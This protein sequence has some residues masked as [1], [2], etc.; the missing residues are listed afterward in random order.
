MWEKRNIHRE[1]SW[2]RCVWFRFRMLVA[3][4]TLNLEYIN[5]SERILL[6]KRNAQMA[7]FRGTSAIMS[8][9]E[10]REL[11]EV[12][13]GA[14]PIRLKTQ[15]HWRTPALPFW[16]NLKF[17]NLSSFTYKGWSVWDLNPVFG[18]SYIKLK[19]QNVKPVAFSFPS[20][21]LTSPLFL[22][23]VGTHLR[24]CTVL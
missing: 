19:A 7:W 1:S 11:W 12:G 10:R 2:T 24:D 17:H 16:L 23:E 18:H 14:V 6:S 22:P 20:A 13:G 21:V 3:R 9:L 8:Q 5:L 15:L 4:P